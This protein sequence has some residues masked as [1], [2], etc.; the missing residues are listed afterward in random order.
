MRT[1]VLASLLSLFLSGCAF[2]PMATP[3]EESQAKAF[4]P[5]TGMTGLYIYRN[6]YRGGAI[7]MQVTVDGRI[8]GKTVAN[9]FLYTELPPG[10]HVITAD[11]GNTDQIKVN[12]VPGQNIFVHQAIKAGFAAAGSSMRVVDSQEGQSGV[13]ECTMVSSQF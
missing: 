6:E 12:A 1:L 7:K 2:V 8:L 10:R 9:S 3:K 5:S 13:L 11:G 4:T